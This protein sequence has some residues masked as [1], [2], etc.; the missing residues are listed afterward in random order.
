MQY[1]FFRETYVTE[2]I[3]TVTPINASMIYQTVDLQNASPIS[4]TSFYNHIINLLV[5]TKHYLQRVV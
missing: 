1:H 3:F 4:K 2:Q 5:E